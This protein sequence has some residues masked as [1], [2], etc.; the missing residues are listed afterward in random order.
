MT[1]LYIPIQDDKLDQKY[2]LYTVALE[3]GPGED[4]WRV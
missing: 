2:L 3:S 1:E 4:R